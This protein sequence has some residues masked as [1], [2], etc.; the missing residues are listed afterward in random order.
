MTIS[1]LQAAMRIVEGKLY[2]CAHLTMSYPGP[3]VSSA[4]ETLREW[5]KAAEE[6]PEWRHLPAPDRDHA[7]RPLSPQERWVIAH[8]RELADLAVIMRVLRRLTE[9]ER[10]L[11][12]LRY[13]EGASWREVAEHLH[14][15]E[16]QVYKLRDG[17]LHAMAYEFGMLAATE[18]S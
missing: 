16:R 11:V 7:G 10:K 14:V 5:A 13:V 9:L 12:L 2:A 15:S 1:R 17:I 4:Y 18:A 6:H 8:Q 3:P